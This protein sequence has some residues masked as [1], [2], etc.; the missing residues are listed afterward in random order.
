M[1]IACLVSRDECIENGHLA[2]AMYSRV[3]RA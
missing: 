1:I 2:R 3:R